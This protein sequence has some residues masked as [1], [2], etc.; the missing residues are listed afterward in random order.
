[1]ELTCSD[2]EKAPK[3]LRIKN[4]AKCPLTAE[5]RNQSIHCV[6]YHGMKYNNSMGKLLLNS[7]KVYGSISI[8]LCRSFIGLAVK[9]CLKIIFLCDCNPFM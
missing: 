4:G 6:S 5:H 1:M 9:L 2:I 7:Q 3:G 8:E